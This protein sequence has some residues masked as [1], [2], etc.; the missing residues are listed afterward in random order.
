MVAELEGNAIIHKCGKTRQA[1]AGH[2]LSP[3]CG[4]ECFLS[5]GTVSGGVKELG[6][7]FRWGIRWETQS[8]PYLELGTEY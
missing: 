5:N 2:P 3:R 7:G 1:A 6:L 4:A 8:E